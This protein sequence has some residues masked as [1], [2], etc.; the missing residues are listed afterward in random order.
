MRGV[1]AHACRAAKSERGAGSPSHGYRIFNLTRPGVKCSAGG[2][3]PG[4]QPAPRGKQP[5][6]GDA[7]MSLRSPGGCR[8]RRSVPQPPSGAWLPPPSFPLQ[9]GGEEA[10]KKR[11]K[12]EAKPCCEAGP[13]FSSQSPRCACQSHPEEP[14]AGP[15]S[16]QVGAALGAASGGALPRPGK[17]QALGDCP[18]PPGHS[19]QAVLGAPVPSTAGRPRGSILLL[20][21][22]PWLAGQSRAGSPRPSG[23]VSPSRTQRVVIEEPERFGGGVKERRTNE[24]R[25]REARRRRARLHAPAATAPWG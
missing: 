16:T 7:D 3:V 2:G 9:N 1:E 25:E 5:R 8:G 23:T 24:E 18:S 19:R 21:A 20:G 13:E 12:G 10:D 22:G 17:S 11:S 4:Q 15:E 14:L 6:Q